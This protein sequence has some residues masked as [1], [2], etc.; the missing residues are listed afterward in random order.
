MAP[1]LQSQGFPSKLIYDHATGSCRTGQTM[2]TIL[3]HES[4][5]K[6][7]D[8]GDG[9]AGL[10]RGG[11][12]GSLPVRG[13]TRQTLILAAAGPWLGGPQCAPGEQTQQR[14]SGTRRLHAPWRT[15]RTA[16]EPES[17][18][19]QTRSLGVALT[20]TLPESRRDQPHFTD[21][22]LRLREVQQGLPANR[23]TPNEGD[24]RAGCFHRGGEGGAGAGAGRGPAQTPAVLCAEEAP[25]VSPAAPQ[26]P[27]AC[28]RSARGGRSASQGAARTPARPRPPLEPRA[29]PA[30]RRADGPRTRSRPRAPRESQAT[31]HGARARGAAADAGGQRRREPTGTAPRLTVA[32]PR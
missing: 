10:V 32:A 30:G 21:E 6:V 18:V 4:K 19:F 23:K 3:K 16:D 22:M 2:S 27:G 5:K 29:G 1:M 9:K 7:R 8:G 31:K 15:Q 24:R 12:G 14:G 25:A 20:T 17:A 26:S 13:E 28:G 11:G